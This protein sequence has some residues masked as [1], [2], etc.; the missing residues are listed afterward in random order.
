MNFSALA[1][2]LVPILLAAGRN[3]ATAGGWMPILVIL[4]LFLAFVVLA[5]ILGLR[6]QRQARAQMAALAERFHLELRQPPAAGL[7]LRSPPIVEGT[8]RNRTV[9]FFTYTT[10]SGKS[11][12]HWC[13]VAAAA[14]GAGSFTLDL[15][16]QNF[17]THIGVALGMQ[18]IQ[19]GDPAFDP[20]FVV[21]SNDAAYTEAALLPEIRA[22][23]VTE[24]G[25]GA[26]GHVSVKGGEVRYAEMGSFSRD[27]QV[28]RLADM[29]E[30]V[31]DLAEVAEVYRKS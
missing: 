29:L 20:L 25:R 9:R 17:L 6:Q 8:H 14:A 22:R 26:L 15:F 7:G 2:A 11:Q 3:R 30:V 21:K 27:V 19:V 10:S 31:C 13:A 18:D 4:P 28:A 16:P 12:T 24:R 5:V 1:S 23:L